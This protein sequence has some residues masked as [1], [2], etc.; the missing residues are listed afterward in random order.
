MLWQSTIF[1]FI[2]EEVVPKHHHPAGGGRG[3]RKGSPGLEEFSIDCGQRS[4]RE[5]NNESTTAALKQ[6]LILQICSPEPNSKRPLTSGLHSK[7]NEESARMVRLV[8]RFVQS[9]Q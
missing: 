9:S 5:P 3:I 8:E 6:R 7:S 1:C 4:T 2:R